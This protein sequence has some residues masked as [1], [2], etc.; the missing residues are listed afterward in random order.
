MQI[1]PKDSHI[2]DSNNLKSSHK[3]KHVVAR[4]LGS[5]SSLTLVYRGIS[6]KR[7]AAINYM[8]VPT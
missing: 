6:N 8:F 1:K 5:N 7:T 3:N 2:S 4:L